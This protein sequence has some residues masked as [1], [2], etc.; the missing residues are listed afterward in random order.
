[1]FHDHLS[2]ISQ[3]DEFLKE[4]NSGFDKVFF[5]FLYRDKQNNHNQF[6]LCSMCIY[7]LQCS[8]AVLKFNLC[9]QSPQTKV[10][11]AFKVK[12]IAERDQKESCLT[13]PLCDY[14]KA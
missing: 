1:M 12:A 13:L 3:K 2:N 7:V 11:G 14:M 10:Y 5:F 6:G 4:K 8:W 9:V